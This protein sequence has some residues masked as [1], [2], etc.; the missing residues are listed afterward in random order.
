MTG[1]LSPD[2]ALGT[3]W[4]HVGPDPYD[5]FFVSKLTRAANGANANVADQAYWVYVGFMDRN[6]LFQGITLQQA[7]IAGVGAQAAEVVFASTPIGPCRGT[8]TLTK[9]GNADS[10]LSDLTAGTSAIIRPGAPMNVLVTAGTHLW[11]GFRQA[12]ATTQ[13]G[14]E[15]L[16]DDMSQGA[17]LITATAGALTGGGPWVGTVPTFSATAQAPMMMATLD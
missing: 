2:P 10:N 16:T 12:M 17:I 5:R 8:Q 6:R 7:A 15:C 14:F 4:K 9:I 13:A 11:C 1:D 3:T